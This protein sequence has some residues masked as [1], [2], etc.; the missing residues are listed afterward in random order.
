MRSL[1]AR[2]PFDSYILLEPSFGYGDYPPGSKSEALRLGDHLILFCFIRIF[3]WVRRLS[4]WEERSEAFLLGVHLILLYS[5]RISLSTP[6]IFLC[7]W[8]VGGG[9]CP[10]FLVFN[11][12]H[13]NN[14]CRWL[15]D[16]YMCG[17]GIV[18]EQKSYGFKIW[19]SWR[20]GFMKTKIPICRAIFWILCMNLQF[21]SWNPPF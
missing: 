12:L 3:Y 8:W 9:W 15:I 2:G 10:N 6:V 13:T 17:K 11:F 16:I 4:P 1:T 19:R 14:I 21:W 7:L 20:L 18:A 5:I